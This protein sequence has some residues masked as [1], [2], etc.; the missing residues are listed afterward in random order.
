[1]HSVLVRYHEVALKKGN[2]SYFVERLKGNLVSAVKG[3]GLRESKTL[4]GRLLLT[5]GAERD[6]EE[7]RRRVQSVFGV[8]NF[9][10]VARTP[11]DLKVLES[12]ILASLNGKSFGSFRV[13]TKREDKRFPLTSPEINAQ[14]GAAVKERSGARVDL[15]NAE[16]TISIEIGKD[17]FI[18]EGFF[19]PV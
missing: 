17:G 8:A 10:F 5:F 6:R 1:M 7:I 16:L 2:R 12:E 9:S 15:K 19:G 4:S 11:P 13:D 14:I 18:I 3:L